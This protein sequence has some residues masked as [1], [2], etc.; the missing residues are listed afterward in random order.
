MPRY[1]HQTQNHDIIGTGVKKKSIRNYKLI[2]A[3]RSMAMSFGILKKWQE[4]SI[5][6]NA[7]TKVIRH[8]EEMA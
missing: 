2:K 5:Y 7:N 4:Y 8:P 6:R 1:T 3:D